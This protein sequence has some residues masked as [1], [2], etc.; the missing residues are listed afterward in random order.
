MSLFDED[1]FQKGL[2][3]RK[4][5]LGDA[6]VQKSLD[7]ADD[8]T[9][10]LDEF[11]QVELYEAQ[12]EQV[13]PHLDLQPDIILADPPRGGISRKAMDGIINL[14]AQIFVYVSCD[15]ATLARDAGALVH[16]KGYRLAAAGVI[17]MFPQT[18]HVESVALFER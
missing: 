3:Q 17:N 12:V 11:D 15:P 16:L 13:A 14:E 6:Y 4:G 8:F 5:T 9:L 2:A 10:N 18:A 1:L 7:A